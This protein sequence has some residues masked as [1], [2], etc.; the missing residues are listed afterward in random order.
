MSLNKVLI[1]TFSIVG[2]IVITVFYTLYKT[3]KQ[4]QKIEELRHDFNVVALKHHKLHDLQVKA[5]NG[6]TPSQND[7]NDEISQPN[8]QNDNSSNRVPNSSHS[9]PPK[10]YGNSRGPTVVHFDRNQTDRRPQPTSSHPHRSQNGSSNNV[11]FQEDDI[12][13]EDLLEREF[14]ESEEYETESEE[15]EAPPPPP[16]TK[17]K[18]KGKNARGKIKMKKTHDP[19]KG[20][21]RADP[22]EDTRAIAARLQRQAEEG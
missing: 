12:D 8:P 1:A 5:I 4:N 21:K 14:E 19:M 9:Q 10:N 17:A 20:E 2:F 11:R 16:K 3:S 15:S 13:S 22:M 7:N 18:S 6:L